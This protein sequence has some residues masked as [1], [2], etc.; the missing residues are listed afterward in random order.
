MRIGY[1]L[2]SDRE[3][4]ESVR[5]RLPIWNVNGLAEAFL[6][7]A[8]RYRCE[9]EASCEL[10]RDTTRE[11]YGQLSALS[12]IEAIEPDANFVFCRI[13][14]EGVTAPDLVRQLYVTHNILIKD[15]AAKSMLDADRF[16]R[17]ASRTPV[18]N[19]RLVEALATLL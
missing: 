2:T 18:E 9:F 13:T 15:C 12:G 4:A 6:R 5:A 14:A 11:L 8:G 1:L 10:V 3:F 16:L 7:S 19:R 17:I